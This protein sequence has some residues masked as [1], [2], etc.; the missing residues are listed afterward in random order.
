M[1][2]FS[3]IEQEG[4][5]PRPLPYEGQWVPQFPEWLCNEKVSPTYWFHFDFTLLGWREV[6]L[7]ER[8]HTEN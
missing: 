6:L 4:K 2:S 8:K 7:L 3:I 1:Q 5:D